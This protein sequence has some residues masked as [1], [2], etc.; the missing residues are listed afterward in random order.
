MKCIRAEGSRAARFRKTAQALFLLSF[1][2]LFLFR[3]AGAKL[4][5]MAILHDLNPGWTKLRI[6]IP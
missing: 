5:N 1:A 3:F 6:G 2:L 4:G